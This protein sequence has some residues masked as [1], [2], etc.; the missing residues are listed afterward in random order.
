MRAT[1]P[2]ILKL[3][4]ISSLGP[5]TPVAITGCARCSTTTG[6]T[7]T[8]TGS[9]AGG[10]SA[11]PRSQAAIAS[12]NAR[13]ASEWIRMVGSTS[14][15]Q[16]TERG[17]T[18][19]VDE[20]DGV[21]IGREHEVQLGVRETGARVGELE[22]GCDA[23]LV[24]TADQREGAARCVHAGT[25]GG[26]RLVRNTCSVVRIAH[27]E[28]DAIG[29]VEARRARTIDIRGR[30]VAARGVAPAGEQVP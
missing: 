2:S 28:L 26:D 11:R 4:A 20:T 29:E 3:S 6:A 1:M 24:A 5:S 12:V 14:E 30:G 10:A 18:L 9:L 27:L 23:F 21:A 16:V 13:R 19:Q 22:G 15:R 17:G 8:D 7:R 25:S